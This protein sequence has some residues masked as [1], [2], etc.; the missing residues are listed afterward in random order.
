MNIAL[1]FDSS[2]AR[3]ARLSVFTAIASNRKSD[4]TFYL[5]SDSL[6]NC[7]LD[8]FELIRE[9]A[10]KD[11]GTRCVIKHIDIQSHADLLSGLPRTVPY[12][13]MET[14]GKGD[15]N[16]AT[17]Q[18]RGLEPE[19]KELPPVVGCPKEAYYRLV[20]P[21]LIAE[22]R[23]LYLDTDALIL[24]DISPLWNTVLGDKLVAGCPD[25]AVEQHR[26][27]KK[28]IQIMPEEPYINAGVMLLNLRQI[29]EERLDEKWLMM[30]NDGARRFKLCDQDIINVTTQQRKIILDPIYNAAFCTMQPPTYR[31]I[32]YFPEANIAI[33][34][35]AGMK[36]WDPRISVAT[37]HYKIWKT[38]RLEYESVIKDEC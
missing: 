16:W 2:W 30:A 17:I 8:M 5:I 28:S 21:T 19:Y 20:I 35:W 1:T 36:P 12:V 32:A 34:H 11:G 33:I 15:R 13:F 38:K 7:D 3:Q 14:R 26:S 37:P 31:Q 24:K 18:G 25:I 9:S 10:C 4:L 27:H 22:E 23:V 29:R 6:S